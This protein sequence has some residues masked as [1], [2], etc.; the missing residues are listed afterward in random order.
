MQNSSKQTVS[1]S[2]LLSGTLTGHPTC[3][4]LP[5]FHTGD[6]CGFLTSAWASDMKLTAQQLRLMPTLQPATGHIAPHLYRTSGAEHGSQ[7][8]SMTT[9]KLQQLTLCVS[10]QSILHLWAS[11]QLPANSSTM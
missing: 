10:S 3:P 1:H 7:L 8:P 6:Q 9:T 5:Y 4:T 11:L 2:R